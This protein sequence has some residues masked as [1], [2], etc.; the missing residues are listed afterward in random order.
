MIIWKL[1]M[2]TAWQNYCVITTCDLK[3]GHILDD[4]IVTMSQLIFIECHVQK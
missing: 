4:V 3:R 2:R 1:D